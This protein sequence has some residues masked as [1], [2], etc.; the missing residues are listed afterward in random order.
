MAR[1]DRDKSHL[2]LI[3]GGKKDINW[4]KVYNIALL[5]LVVGLYV[6][7]LIGR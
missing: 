7:F 5:C 4:Q 3:K 6:L 1:L 2:K